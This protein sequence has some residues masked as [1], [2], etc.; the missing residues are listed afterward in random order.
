MTIS[1]S[2]VTLLVLALL[3]SP[4]W[5]EGGDPEGAVEQVDGPKPKIIS[6]GQSADGVHAFL[7]VTPKG[8][9]VFMGKSDDLGEIDVLSMQRTKGGFL[10]DTLEEGELL[11]ETGRTPRVI[12]PGIPGFVSP[13]P[14]IVFG[15]AADPGLLDQ[16]R[17]KLPGSTPKATV[18]VE[19]PA[20]GAVVRFPRGAASAGPGTQRGPVAQ[21]ARAPRARLRARSMSRGRALPRAR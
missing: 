7:A 17:R 21:N 12:K 14:T 1:R 13:R 20:E 11:F 8:P 9:M 15:R 16:V 5:A 6:S 10:I 3:T 18:S 2:S 19:I 4:A